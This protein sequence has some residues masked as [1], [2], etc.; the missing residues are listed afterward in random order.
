[1]ILECA[2]L[3]VTPGR[4]V[5]FEAA[6]AEARPLIEGSSGFISVRLERCIERPS[7]FLLLVEWESLDAHL[8]GFRESQAYLRWRDLLHHFYEPGVLVEHY[9][10]VA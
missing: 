8:V 4:E 10:V 6:Y 9:S 2:I 1:M 3:P 5:E 7:A